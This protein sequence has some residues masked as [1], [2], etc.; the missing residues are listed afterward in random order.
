[1]AIDQYLKVAAGHLRRAADATKKE[2]DEM[3]YQMDTAV[4]ERQDQ[5]ATWR[6]QEQIRKADLIEAKEDAEKIGIARDLA[7]LKTQI[8]KTEREINDLRQ[9]TQQ[10]MA[11]KEQDMNMLTSKARELEGMA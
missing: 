11:S 7:Y 8:S 4:K 5:I 6:R 9:K 1:M 10:D 2:L 3:R